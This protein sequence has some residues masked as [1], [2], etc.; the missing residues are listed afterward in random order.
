MC[1]Y[2]SWKRTL[3]FDWL[4]CRCDLCRIYS[5]RLCWWLID[6]TLSNKFIY[7]YC[8]CQWTAFV[9]L[10]YLDNSLN[11][12]AL[13]VLQCQARL[14]CPS[15]SCPA[16]SGPASLS[17]IFLSCNV[18]PCKFGCPSLSCPAISVNPTRRGGHERTDQWCIRLLDP[19]ASQMME[20]LGSVFELF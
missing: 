6:G 11:I 15:L 9:L 5:I 7:G 19:Q 12:Q 17:V 14:V 1:S 3:V 16:K 2:C 4:C 13:L 18:R 10:V 20:M 8:T